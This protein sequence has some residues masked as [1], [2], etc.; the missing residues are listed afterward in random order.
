MKIITFILCV[1]VSS[2]ATA[3]DKHQHPGVTS[4]AIESYN[5]CMQLLEQPEIYRNQARE[6]I[7]FTRLEDQSP[8]LER[9]FNWHFHDAYDCHS[10]KRMKRRFGLIDTSL[11]NIYRRR[12]EALCELTDESDPES[13]SSAE[14]TGRILHYIQDMAVPAHVAPVYH[15]KP[16]GWFQRLFVP[17]EPS[18][19]DELFTQHNINQLNLPDYTRDQ[20]VDFYHS[21]NDKTYTLFTLLD[22][23]AELTRDNIRSDINVPADHVWANRQWQDVLWPLRQADSNDADFLHQ[24]YGKYGFLKFHIHLDMSE[25]SLDKYQYQAAANFFRQQYALVREYT[26]RALML[27]RSGNVQGDQC[28]QAEPVCTANTTR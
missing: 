4:D 13:V 15:S 7:L 24:E 21:A 26:V 6:I 17:D 8:L 28:Y 9:A 10:E 16:E 12:V 11:H 25:D 22:E 3:I 27:I 19:F 1:L 20:C 18:A 14:K 23:L 5:N 2:S